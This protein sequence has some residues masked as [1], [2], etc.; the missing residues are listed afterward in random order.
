MELL[1]GKLI[2]PISVMES[3]LFSNKEIFI[4]G[5]T[6]ASPKQIIC[7]E[8]DIN[9]TKV[10][11]VDGRS[12][13]IAT[14]LKKMENRF[15]T[16]PHFYRINRSLIINLDFIKHVEAEKITLVNGHSFMPSRRRKKAFLELISF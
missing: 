7:I 13:Y 6:F 15:R 5:R 9:Y 4:G 14:T 12:A 1:G 16:I 3:I 11:Y 8:A 10:Y 2:K